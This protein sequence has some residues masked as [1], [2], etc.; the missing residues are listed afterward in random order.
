MHFWDVVVDRPVFVHEYAEAHAGLI[1]LRASE[2][3]HLLFPLAPAGG[4]LTAQFLAAVEVRELG[5]KVGSLESEGEVV[6]GALDF[7]LTGV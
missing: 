4:D 7:L 1:L 3:K 2:V 5:A 6:P